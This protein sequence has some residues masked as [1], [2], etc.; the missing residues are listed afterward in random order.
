MSH[1]SETKTLSGSNSMSLAN[2]IE[3]LV[4][5]LNP[6]IA[7]E[8]RHNQRHPLPVLLRLTPIGANGQLERDRAAIVLGKDVSRTGL[9]F[10]HER[11]LHYRRA[12]VSLEHPDFGWFAA[13]LDLNWC[14]FTKPGWY[15]SGGRLIVEVNL[16]QMAYGVNSSPIPVAAICRSSNCH[17]SP[18]FDGT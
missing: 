16:D 8:R 7:V 15:I 10:F 18:S 6:Q 14:R 5:Q 4:S 12:I 13:E 3:T 17:E 2:R 11:P 9:S 1:S